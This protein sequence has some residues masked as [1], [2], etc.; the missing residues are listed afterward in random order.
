[1]S[2]NIN[3]NDTDKVNIKIS[4]LN[5][6]QNI[7]NRMA[8]FSLA[9]KTASVTTLTALLAYSASDT[10]SDN[11]K[12]WMFFIPWLFFAG[13]H[14]FFLRLEKIFRSLYNNSANQS[15]ISFSDFSID[16]NKLRSIYSPLHRT[17][18]SLPFLLFHLILIAIVSISFLK[19][20]GIL[21][22]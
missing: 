13:Y 2:T 9:M 14:A 5:I 10:V 20:Q 21:C 22:F 16:K 6:L 3:L 19:I 4:Y 12:L 7:I 15:D 18:F 17:I 8:T 1:M 11:F